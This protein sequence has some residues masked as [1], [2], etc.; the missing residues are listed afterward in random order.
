MKKNRNTKPTSMIATIASAAVMLSL[1]C[2][3]NGG[4]VNGFTS[5]DHR[6]VAPILSSS[7][8]P[9]TKKDNREAAAS[10]VSF[11]VVKGSNFD[12]DNGGDSII[13]G[14]ASTGT[15]AMTTANG[16]SSNK[17]GYIP[18]SLF[19]SSSSMQMSPRTSVSWEE[20]KTMNNR[21]WDA[22]VNTLYV[23]IS[24]GIVL[25]LSGYAYSFNLPTDTTTT[26]TT[27]SA[28]TTNEKLPLLRIIPVKQH[29]EEL[30]W[31]QEIERY[32]QMYGQEYNNK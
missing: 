8:S 11:L 3:T 32:D 31:K 25:N 20:M 12:N 19:L 14:E 7:V 21:F 17:R 5:I 4:I 15:P 24:L 29:R 28:A 27:T 18:F 16:N 9:L 6:A 1:A 30:Q 23:V 22:V 2:N 13:G 10:S 26:T